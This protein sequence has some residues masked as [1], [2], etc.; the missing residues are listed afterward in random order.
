MP[1]CLEYVSGTELHNM[2][3]IF[4]H[5]THGSVRLWRRSDTPYTS[6]C[7]DDVIFAYNGIYKG[8]SIPLQQVAPLRRRVQDNAPAASCWLRHVP[9][10]CGRRD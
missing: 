3:A 1:V 4:V 2:S 10:D 8:M 9:D 7:M 6:G 5:V